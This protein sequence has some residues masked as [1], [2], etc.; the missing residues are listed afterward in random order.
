[1]CLSGGLLDAVATLKE[2][3]PESV[4]PQETQLGKDE[5]QTSADTPRLLLAWTPFTLLGYD[6]KA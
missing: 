5:V 2:W 4:L 1:M 3:R 6:P